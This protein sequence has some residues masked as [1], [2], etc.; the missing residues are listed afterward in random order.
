MELVISAHKSVA[1][2]GVVGRAE[3]MHDIMDAERDATLGYLDALTQERGGRRGRARVPTPTTGLVYAHTR[4][5]TSRAGDPC[6]HDHVLVA[7][8]VSMADERGGWK[9]ADTTTWRDHL[10]AATVVGRQAAARVALELG[11]AIEADAGPSGRLGHWR[12]AGV[13][14]EVL[15]VHSK[16]GAE[17][18]AAVKARGSDTY[19]SRQVAARDTRRAK[20]HTPVG[21]LLP[22]WQTELAEVGWEP[23][24]LVASI[25]DAALDRHLPGPLY[26]DELRA[27]VADALGQDGPLSSRKVFNLADVMVAIGPSL[28]GRPPEELPRAVRA[29]VASPEAVPLL[30]VAQARE[31]VWATASV[32]ATEAAIAQSME[33]QAARSDAAAVG[34]N[35]L[36]PA[37]WAKERELGQPLTLGQ[38]DAVI[39]ICTSGHGAE[40]VLGVAGAGKTTALDVVRAAFEDGAYTV[41]GTATS[42][43]AARTLGREA[44]IGEARTLA[45]LLWRLDHGGLRLDART[46][47][48]VDEAAMTDSAGLLRLL[49]C[50]EAAKAKVV[51]VGDDRQLGAVGPGGALRALMERH[52]D[53]VHELSE[54]VRQR[55]REERAALAELRSGDVEVAVGW[56]AEHGRIVA[57]PYRDEVLDR[58][59]DAWAADVAAG[60][61]AAM[62][63]WRRADV[64]EL[65]AQA[66]KH[67]ADKGWLHG[68]ELMVGERSYRAGDR[69][70]TLAPG[71]DGQ[72]VTSE[73]GV[74]ESVDPGAQSL[75]SRMDD[76][77]LQPFGHEDIAPDRLAHGYAVTVHRSQGATVDR[78]HLLADG[79]GRELAYVAMSRARECS[80][81]YV[82]ADDLGQAKQD[83]VRDWSAERRQTWAIDSGTPATTALEVEHH[84]QA[85]AEL[86]GALHRA[87]LQAERTAVAQ[88]IPA[89]PT[90]EVRGVE[91][92]LQ[93]TRKRI[94]DLETGLGPYR[95]T[96]TGWAAQA[97]LRARAAR[98]KAEGF[99]QEAGWRLRRSW[100]QKA[101]EWAAHEADA[102]DRF[103]RLG[104]PERQRLAAEIGKLEQ[105][106]EELSAAKVERE[107]WLGDHPEAGFRLDRLDRE[108]AGLESELAVEGNGPELA[109]PGASEPLRVIDPPRPEPDIDLGM[110]LGL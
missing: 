98:I 37:M 73:R 108:L 67:F 88:A 54:N 53:A 107:Q 25:E 6:P 87:R 66:R 26:E 39:G 51:L 57:A 44:G 58:L 43:Q 62:L 99:S 105:R 100:K 80:T 109:E 101:K 18:T 93:A 27:I 41:V 38:S 12:I 22:R 21:E 20:G 90:F 46:V 71:A 15:K 3:D 52:P 10:H 55:D 97:A 78:A 30:G 1:E 94:S 81:A 56:Y 110:D 104:A 24:A 47:V 102:T 96:E 33:T 28:Y 64:A 2:L 65:N 14:D 89:D 19:R 61:D 75:R 11:Y 91:N 9:A 40:L 83:L 34:A 23:G 76:G 82:M 70:V 49:A 92:D 77:R 68:E 42:G 35:S 74:V 103:E 69:I 106:R 4:H 85:P 60:R 36:H 79:G 50:V 5:A 86:R 45:S 29:V 31:R 84:E 32:L 13:P 63:A 8:L 95:G 17:I 48:I 7:N 72:L 16:R 59:V